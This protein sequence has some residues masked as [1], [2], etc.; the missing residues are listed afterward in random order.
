MLNSNLFILNKDDICLCEQLAIAFK[1]KK[2]W[3]GQWG[4]GLLN[5]NNLYC[6]YATEFIG[7][8]GELA[9]SRIT[10]QLIDKEVREHGNQTDFKFKILS[11]KHKI[12]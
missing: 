11:D 1:K 12:F 9:F 6:D 7:I 2:L 5:D 8:L 10:G 3:S 4:N